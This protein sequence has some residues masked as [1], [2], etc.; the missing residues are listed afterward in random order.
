MK[1]TSTWNDHEVEMQEGNLDGWEFADDFFPW[2][3]PSSRGLMVCVTDWD[4]G[5]DGWESVSVGIRVEELLPRMLEAHIEEM[6]DIAEALATA[7]SLDRMAAAIRA[8]VAFKAEGPQ[9]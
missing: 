9:P 4:I 1:N 7:D 6:S 2:I 3:Y 5:D 8:R